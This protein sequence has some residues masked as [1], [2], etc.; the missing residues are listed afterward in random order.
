MMKQH[1]FVYFIAIVFS[2]ISIFKTLFGLSAPSPQG[3]GAKQLRL[4]GYHVVPLATDPAKQGRDFSHGPIQHFQL[5]DKGTPQPLVLTLMPIRS[6]N[7]KTLQMARM[8]EF[9]EKFY[10]RQ[11]HLQLIRSATSQKSRSHQHQEVAIGRGPLTTYPS[12]VRLQ[13]CLM[14]GGRAAVTMAS[15]QHHMYEQRA[16]ELA[17]DP[18]QARLSRFLGLQPNTHWECLAIQLESPEAPGAES[19][20]I[21]T[22]SRLCET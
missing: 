14:P 3:E 12:V 10:L 18:I 2:L 4:T 17:R 7:E 16:H 1:R 5:Q 21:E 19:T 11:R 13:S 15:I 9:E 22:W 8:A 20:L 6:R